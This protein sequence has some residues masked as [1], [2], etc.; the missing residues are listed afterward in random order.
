M[1]IPASDYDLDAGLSGLG[2]RQELNPIL[3]S[4]LT[5]NAST[6]L[7]PVTFPFM[8]RVNETPTPDELEIRNPANTSFIKWGEITDTAVTLFSNGAAV[9]SLATAQTFTQP[10]TIDTSGVAGS[11]T[12]A[13]DQSSGIVARIPMIGHNSV[14]SNVTGVNLVCRVVIN[15][16][17]SEDFNFEVE[18]VR[19][20]STVTLAT[21]GS[22]SDFRRSGGGG[23]L[24][25]DTVRQA[26]VALSQITREAA[27]RLGIGGNFSAGFT[28]VQANEGSLFT[29]NGGTAQ[30]VTLRPLA[31][32]TIMFFSNDTNGA[33]NL[34][35][36]S[37]TSPNDVNL[38]TTRLTLA[39]VASQTPMCCVVWSQAAGNE[40]TILGNNT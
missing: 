37:D 29:F 17:G 35:F 38:N 14:G 22:F 3:E 34:T 28:P 31:E 23:I 2:F 7:P 12:V 11:L 9:P 5:L 24:D 19:G 40:V 4:L 1:T 39:G 32:N 18:V 8:L 13:S 30:Q 15:T 36:A 26:G 6:S 27:G 16:S 20:G 21:L 10:Q 25:A 33:A